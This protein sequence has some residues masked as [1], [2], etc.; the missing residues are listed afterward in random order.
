MD[1]ASTPIGELGEAGILRR[2][3]GEAPDASPVADPRVLIGPG[4]DAAV[5]AVGSGRLIA[6]TDSLIEGHDF[7]TET[8]TGELIGRKAAVQNLAD[9]VAMGGRPLALLAAVST[10]ASTP[11]GLLQD[12]M[13]GLWTVARRYGAD[14]VGG[15]LGRADRLTL[16]ITALGELDAQRAP[17]RRDGARPG[18]ALVIGADQLGLSAAGLAL[19]LSGRCRIRP[20]GACGADGAEPEIHW[21]DRELGPGPLDALARRALLWHDAPDPVLDLDTTTLTAGLDLSDGLL[22]DAGRIAAASGMR[23][24][25]DTSTLSGDIGVL[26]PLAEALGADARSWV[27]TGGEE[28]CL[29]GTC[30]PDA[31]PTGFRV[32]GTV[33]A[34]E[35]GEAGG[36]VTVDG[37]APKALGWDHFA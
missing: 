19:V 21:D 23:I 29:L 5:L 13:R 32:I 10:P 30:P 22:R 17:L 6:T 18:D 9:V 37:E 33:V 24:D 35:E 20:V 14:V 15:D 16:T 28:H 1:E 8:T 7:L 26:A 27:L 34:G 12:V 36:T 31:V 3:L 25:V 4:D 11:I 2:I